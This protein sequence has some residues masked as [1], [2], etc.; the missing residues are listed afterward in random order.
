MNRRELAQANWAAWQS[1][2][3]LLDSTEKGHA[4]CALLTILASSIDP[5]CWDR[6]THEALGLWARDEAVPLR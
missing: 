2:I 6:V 3:Q 4:H 1:K 5:E